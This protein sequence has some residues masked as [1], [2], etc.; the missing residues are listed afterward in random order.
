MDCNIL[1]PRNF[2]WRR[3]YLCSPLCFPAEYR[4]IIPHEALRTQAEHVSTS[5]KS[6]FWGSRG[7]AYCMTIAIT[8]AILN[9]N[10]SHA[11]VNNSLFSGVVPSYY[12]QAKSA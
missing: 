7:T 3:A 6:S 11:V 8:N 4:R 5:Q 1:I 10:V 2:L 9:Q 12:Q